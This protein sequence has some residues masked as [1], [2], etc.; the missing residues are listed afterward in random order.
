MAFSEKKPLLL[1]RGLQRVWQQNGSAP[2][3]SVAL[4]APASRF[5]SYAPP[6]AASQVIST[7]PISVLFHSFF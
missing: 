7:Q 2:L 1:Q 5:P 3:K 4:F 6:A